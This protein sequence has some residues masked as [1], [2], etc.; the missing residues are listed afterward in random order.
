MNKFISIPIL[1]SL[2]LLSTSCGSL[3]TDSM[4]ALYSIPLTL[5]IHPYSAKG[6]LDKSFGNNG[7]VTAEI[8]GDD[9]ASTWGNSMV[10]D[11]RGRIYVAGSLEKKN[12]KNE[13]VLWRYNHDGSPDTSFGING[14]IRSVGAAMNWNADGSDI[15]CGLA[16]DKKDKIFIV[17]S[18]KNINND[19]D[20]VVLVYEESI[21]NKL[22]LFAKSDLASYHNSTNSDDMGNSIKVDEYGRVLVTGA[23]SDYNNQ[24]Y[25][26]TWRFNPE[27]IPDVS[28]GSN[29]YGVVLSN[30]TEGHREKSAFSYGI[31]LAIDE[32]GRIL[33]AGAT[34]NDESNYFFD[35][36]SLWRLNENGTPDINFGKGGL[37]IYDGAAN[38]DEPGGIDAGYNVFAVKK[39]R[40]FIIGLTGDYNNQNAYLIIWCYNNDGILDKKFGNNGKI[41][42]PDDKGWFQ[43]STIDNNGRFIIG[44]NV[45]SSG[46]GFRRY[47]ENGIPDHSFGNNGLV[48]FPKNKDKLVSVCSFATDTQGRIFI[49]GYTG[50]MT[51][52]SQMTILKYK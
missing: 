5:F 11:K 39:N 28:F 52:N 10:I 45:D 27:G 9:V 8:A 33:V 2:I 43:P 18:S 14:Y 41:I 44:A 23:S 46:N 42:I 32:I 22:R 6:I 26:V 7:V 3:F 12:N 36:M 21:N 49:V 20:M 19:E 34:F 30:G 35:C 16:I 1:L 50:D 51:T 13:I 40:I 47:D 17:G 15:G 25:M 31:N 4:K 24:Q 48:I 37:V 29:M 38:N